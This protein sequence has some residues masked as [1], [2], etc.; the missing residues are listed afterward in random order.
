MLDDILYNKYYCDQQ[1]FAVG[2][3]GK[4]SKMKKSVL[5]QH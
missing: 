5:I 1:H 2:H 3:Y 4:K